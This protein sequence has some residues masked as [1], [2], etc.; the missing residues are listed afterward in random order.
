M[1]GM[2]SS[3]VRA[4][5]AAAGESRAASA[6]TTTAFHSTPLELSKLVPA[7]QAVWGPAYGPLTVRCELGCKSGD[8]VAA[9]DLDAVERV[10]ILAPS[11]PRFRARRAEVT[12]GPDRGDHAR[13]ER[14]ERIGE[15]IHRNMKRP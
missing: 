6:A 3:D 5:T 2:I 10:E 1:P 15:E 12:G 4:A 11:Q 14:A 7:L 9:I 8:A 13:V